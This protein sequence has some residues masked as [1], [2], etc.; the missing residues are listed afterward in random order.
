MSSPPTSAETP[1]AAPDLATL[2]RD[3]VVHVVDDDQAIRDGLSWLL[4][5]RRLMSELHHGGESLLSQF[6]AE[7]AHAAAEGAGPACVLLDLR[8]P[9]LSGV[10]VFD[11]LRRRDLLARLPVIFL[12]GHGDVPTAVESMKNGAFDF[13]EKPF[14]GNALV[15][16][17]L[18]ALQS[19]ALHLLECRR[20]S[21]D[22]RVVE[23]LTHR[24]REVLLLALDGLP[25]KRIA[26][27]MGISVRTAELHRSR[28]LS[29][30]DCHA[31]VDAVR[32]REAMLRT[33]PAE[34]EGD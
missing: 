22:D 6:P 29:K 24:E 32:W 25:N 4:R 13:V 27:T 9:G 14:A 18:A 2:Q 28:G 23:R 5:S 34:G 11:E 17:V 12:T 33:A 10:Q 21:G 7:Q 30:L 19:S 8:M 31:I 16:K 3:A 26:D 15:D 20:L 1:A